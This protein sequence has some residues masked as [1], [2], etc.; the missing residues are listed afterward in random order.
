VRSEREYLIKIVN[1]KGKITH[2]LKFPENKKE[3]MDLVIN[4]M[5]LYERARK[6]HFLTKDLFNAIK[7]L[8]TVIKKA[9]YH[10][11]LFRYPVLLKHFA[12]LLKAEPEDLLE[13][14]VYGK[15]REKEHAVCHVCGCSL[16]YPAYVIFKTHDGKEVKRSESIGIKCL[17]SIYETILDLVEKIELNTEKVAELERKLEAITNKESKPATVSTQ[18]EKVNTSFTENGENKT[19]T[20]ARTEG[21]FSK[22]EELEN[23]NANKTEI[24]SENDENSEKP[25]ANST[26]ETLSELD[27][28][29]K[30]LNARIDAVEKN[31]TQLTL[32]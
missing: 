32:F 17:N 31:L 26:V 23:T 7:L 15:V 27:E 30:K 8:A 9:G 21:I 11:Y 13:E 4:L 20:H 14:V 16:V 1:Y 22:P 6:Y 19:D 10:L 29:S 18:A 2:K 12:D 24:S 28:K 3:A 5:R 25:L